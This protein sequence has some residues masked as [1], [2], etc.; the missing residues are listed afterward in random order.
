M[1]IISRIP[2]PGNDLAE[3]RREHLQAID[4]LRAADEW[5]RPIALARE[6]QAR[7]LRLAMEAVELK[8]H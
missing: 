1:R 6:R 3:A 5:A 2:D 7:S 4:R 8:A